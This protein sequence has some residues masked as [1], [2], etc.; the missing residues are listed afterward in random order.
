MDLNKFSSPGSPL[1]GG[2]LPPLLPVMLLTSGADSS[3]PQGCAAGLQ[4]PVPVAAS[5][6][7]VSPVRGEQSPATSSGAIG[8]PTAPDGA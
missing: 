2:V 4:P 5:A 7:P 6:A 1:A 3:R 8:M